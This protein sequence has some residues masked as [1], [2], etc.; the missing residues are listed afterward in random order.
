MKSFALPALPQN[1]DTFAPPVDP[2]LLYISMLAWYKLQVYN[3]A[4]T[5][6]FYISQ[7]DESDG[8][9]LITSVNTAVEAALTAIDEC[10]TPPSE[11]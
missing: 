10:F 8:E 3:A 1:I 9:A 11:G 7:I 2:D 5:E 4:R 6:E